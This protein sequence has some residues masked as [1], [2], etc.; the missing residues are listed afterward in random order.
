MCGSDLEGLEV[1]FNEAIVKPFKDL[2]GAT[3]AE[4]AT[5]LARETAEQEQADALTEREDAKALVAAEQLSISQQASSLR[6]SGARDVSARG[7]SGLGGEE[8]DFLGL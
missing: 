6:S 1:L 2:T 8:S 4:E 7:S 5:E 3:A